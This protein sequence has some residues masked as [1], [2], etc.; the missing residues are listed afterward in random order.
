MGVCFCLDLR[1]EP[2]G[3]GVRPHVLL[4][5]GGLH[6]Q[7]RRSFCPPRTPARPRLRRGGAHKAAAD[8]RGHRLSRGRA[9]GVPQCPVPECGLWIV[10]WSNFFFRWVFPHTAIELQRHRSQSGHVPHDR[11]F[12]PQH[13]ICPFVLFCFTPSECRFQTFHHRDTGIK[14]ETPLF[15]LSP[16]R[17]ARPPAP[18][19]RVHLDVCV[20]GR[21]PP[22][23]PPPPPRHLPPPR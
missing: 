10:I 2:R 13:D 7:C 11:T 6:P 4:L 14:R 16:P 3:G 21:A 8:A 19:A 20:P 22:D 5:G 1:F 18:A 12:D 23:G 9:Q 17:P 15:F